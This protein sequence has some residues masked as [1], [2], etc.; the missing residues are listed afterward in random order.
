MLHENFTALPLTEPDL[1]P[2]RDLHCENFALFCFYDL[3]LD[4]MTVMYEL[5]PYPF[6]LY[7]Q[8]KHE[9]RK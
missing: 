1:L 3:D 8:T 6:K 9:L 2:I 4:P 7:P 5:D